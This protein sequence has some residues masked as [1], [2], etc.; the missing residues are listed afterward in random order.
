[1]RME[2]VRTGTMRLVGTIDVPY[3][4]MMVEVDEISG[5]NGKDAEQVYKVNTLFR[6]EGLK[7]KGVG[8]LLIRVK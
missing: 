6:N 4:L 3:F 2:S 8:M 7:N 5:F 1:M